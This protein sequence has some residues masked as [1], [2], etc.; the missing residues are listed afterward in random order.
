MSGWLRW[1]GNNN[2]HSLLQGEVVDLHFLDGPFRDEEALG[3]SRGDRH[4]RQV[5]V[6]FADAGAGSAVAEP[7][8]DR[9]A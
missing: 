9:A 1:L 7:M 2:W 8:A 3:G 6:Q 5:E 4:R